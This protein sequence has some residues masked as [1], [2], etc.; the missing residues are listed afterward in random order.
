MN[1]EEAN[2]SMHPSVLLV[3]DIFTSLVFVTHFRY[4]RRVL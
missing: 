4:E 2:L 1:P 3:L